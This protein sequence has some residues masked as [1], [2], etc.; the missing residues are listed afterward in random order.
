MVRLIGV[1]VDRRDLADQ[2]RRARYCHCAGEQHLAGLCRRYAEYLID[3]AA[4]PTLSLAA[5]SL[6]PISTKAFT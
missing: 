2:H 5:A 1:E 3:H 6:S 4:T